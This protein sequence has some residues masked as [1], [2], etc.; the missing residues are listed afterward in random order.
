MHE[1][2]R[3][4]TYEQDRTLRTIGAAEIEFLED[5]T[6]AFDCEET[7]RRQSKP[8]RFTHEGDRPLV[9]YA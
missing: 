8:A 7:A 5:E 9:S 1:N 4:R 2:V 6:P 3:L